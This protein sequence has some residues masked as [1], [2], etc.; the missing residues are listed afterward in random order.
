M[1]KKHYFIA[2]EKKADLTEGGS[3]N[4]LFQKEWELCSPR[5]SPRYASSRKNTVANWPAL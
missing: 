3:T 1:R 4:Y 2:N 5:N